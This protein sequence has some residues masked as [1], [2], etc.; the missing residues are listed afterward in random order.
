MPDPVA[1]PQWPIVRRVAVQALGAGVIFFLAKLAV[2]AVTDSAAVLADALESTI[3][4]VA[5]GA[6]LYTLRLSNRPPDH[7]HPYGHGKAEFLAVAL[8]G[9]MI[10]LA[11]AMI[12]ITA[13]RRLADP[14]IPVRLDAGMMALAAITVAGAALGVYV[15]GMGRRHRSI[16]LIADGKHLI[17]DVLTTLGVLA[18]LLLV[19]VTGMVWIDPLIAIAV[20]VFIL[21]TGWRL[22]KQS[23]GG[24]MDETD[25]DDMATIRRILDEEI[26]AGEIRAY[27]KVRARHTGAFH[28]VDMHLQVEPTLTVRESH[29]LASRIEKRIEAALGAADATAHVEPWEPEHAGATRRAD[30][31]SA[32]AGLTSRTP[33]SP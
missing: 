27:H 2:F 22:L 17:T 15:L 13:F 14:P 28:W 33:T 20:A 9:S 4:V 19:R 3:N 30:G 25:P 8:E 5:A 16:V 1:D 12:V 11:G 32:D 23:M 18:G 31:S 24:L 6:M 26:A 10:L 7:N 21:L 29:A